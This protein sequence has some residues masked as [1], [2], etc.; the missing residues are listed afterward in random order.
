MPTECSVSCMLSILT[1]FSF[2][3]MTVSLDL[4]VTAKEEGN[5][6]TLTASLNAGAGP[7]ALA[8]VTRKKK[9]AEVLEEEACELLSHFN[10]QNMEALLKVTKN[11]L[12]AIRK[13]I[14]S[15][16]AINFRGNDLT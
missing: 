15:A 12:E 4:L 2:I 6:D 7:L 10:H 9:E 5:S 13:R 3:A 1:V 11:T 8:T 14:H 16:S